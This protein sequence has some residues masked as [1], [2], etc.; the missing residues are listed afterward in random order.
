MSYHIFNIHNAVDYSQ[1]SSLCFSFQKGE[2]TTAQLYSERAP[3]LL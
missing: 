2:E 1:F 3:G